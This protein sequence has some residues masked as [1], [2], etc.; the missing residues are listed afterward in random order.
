M[1]SIRLFKRERFPPALLFRSVLLSTLLLFN[2]VIVAQTLFSGI[3][4]GT[5]KAGTEIRMVFRIS[6]DSAGAYQATLESP[7]QGSIAVKASQVR[8][9]ED[10]VFIEIRQFNAK[11][12]GKIIGDSINGR[13][14]QGTGF[15][16]N[17][18]KVNQP[19]V[20]IRP[21]TPVPPFPYKTEELIYQ[22][23]K[24]TIS[25]GATI[26]IPQGNG[27]FA[28]VLLLTG[29]GQ[30]NRDEEIVGHKPF[31]VIADHLTRNGFIV[32]RVDDRGTGKTTGEVFKSTTADYADDAKVSLNYL[33]T[34][35]EVDKKRIGLIGHSEGGMIAQIIAAARKDIKFIVMLAGPGI[36]TLKLMEEQNEAI[37][38]K[39][40]LTDEYM[41]PY[42]S[43]YTSI[44]K[45]ILAS[46][47]ASAAAKVKTVVNSWIE[48]TPKNIVAA[49]TG[50]RD[51]ASKENFIRQSVSQLGTAW[52]RYFLSY[53]PASNLGKITANVLAL[54]GSEDI[55]VISKTNLAAIDSILKKGKSSKFEV[56]EMAG[57]NH[58]FQEC[59]KCTLSEYSELD[60][61]IS[62]AVLDKITGWMKSVL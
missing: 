42:L 43:L 20:K 7:D 48:S 23:D 36:P 34:R 49:T 16:L 4:E 6:T 52:F 29:S 10:S 17:L 12:S 26:T 19:T 58:L 8:L 45:T 14:I 53:D 24:K 9:I 51:E 39:N 32:L 41:A 28:A 1:F 54:N 15:P 37:L 62:P 61:T 38:A 50:I 25:Y 31:A 44:L 3:W 60:Q 55:Q 22:N 40:G 18:K 5:L 46:D 30:Q 33:Q 13:F 2:F 11:Y 59:K 21:Q 27:P 35:K 56:K 47:S 57:M